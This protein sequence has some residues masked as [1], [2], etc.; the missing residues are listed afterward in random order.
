MGLSYF[1]IVAM[2]ER[3]YPEGEHPRAKTTCKYEIHQDFVARKTQ[4]TRLNVL[5]I[6]KQAKDFL[7]ATIR[8]FVSANIPI[9][10]PEN[11]LLKSFLEKISS[12]KLK[13]AASY[14]NSTLKIFA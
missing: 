4:H 3:K 1:A 8:S 10:K 6:G 13:T 12:N 7:I 11:P 14:R 9:Q 2:N 5:S